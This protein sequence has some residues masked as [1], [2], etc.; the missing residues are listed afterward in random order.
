MTYQDANPSATRIGT[1]SVSCR[2]FIASGGVLFAQF[3]KDAFTLVD[4]G[5][6][7]DERQPVGYF[8][9]GF[10]D[11][12]IDD[13]EIVQYLLAFQSAEIG[14]DLL[15]ATVSLKAVFADSNSPASCRMGTAPTAACP[16]PDRL[17]NVCASS[18]PNQTPP[19]VCGSAVMSILDSPKIYG[20]IP[21]GTTLTP[22]FTIQASM[23]NA[24]QSVDM[25]VG[26]TATTAG[27]SV[28]TQFAKRET[29]N[30]DE[31]SLYYSTD[32]PTGGT[33]SVGGYDINNNEVLETVTYDPRNFFTDYFYETRTYSDLTSTNPTLVALGAP[34]NFDTLDGGFR[35]GLNNTSRP[36]QTSLMAQWSEDINFN[37]RLDGACTIDNAV[38]CT[39]GI[40]KSQGCQRCSLNHATEC[41]VNADCQPPLDPLGNEGTCTYNAGT[42]NFGLGED[43]NINGNNA[44]DKSW[45]TLGGCGWQTKFPGAAGGGVWHT[46]LIRDQAQTDCVA[47][48]A[49]PGKCQQYWIQDD[50]DTIGDNNWWDLLLTP[51]LHKVNQ[52][53]TNGHCSVTT[54]TVCTLSSGCPVGETCIG[55]P[56]YQASIT[57]WA[58]NMLVDIPDTNTQVTMEFDTDI[59]KT[60]GSELFNDATI[61]VQFRGRQ[62]PVSGGNA[63]IT[64]GFNMFHRIN[65]CVDTDGNGSV[66][67][68]GTSQGKLCSADGA[69]TPSNFF[70]DGNDTRLVRGL[71]TTPTTLPALKCTGN[72]GFATACATNADC[73]RHCS[74]KP[75][76]ACI[77]NTQ[78]TLVVNGCSG[79][80]CGACID[81]HPALAGDRCV[82]PFIECSSNADCASVGGTCAVATG[83]DLAR[84]REGSNN[85][86]FYG[87]GGG[88]AAGNHA[89]SSEPYGLPTPLDDDT[90]NGYCSRNDSFNGLDKSVSCESS[91]DC[92]SAG[93]PYASVK[94]C[95]LWKSCSKAPTKGCLNNAGCVLPTE[96]ICDAA[97]PL[98][99]FKDSPDCGAALSNGANPVGGVCTGTTYT[100]V[101]NLPNATADEYVQ[102]NGPGRN[103]GVQVSNGPDL[104]FSTLEDIYGDTG[105]DFQ[106]ALG[107]N[108]REPDPLTKGVP[109]GYGLA[110][111]DMV[112]SWKETRL[113]L[114][115]HTCSNAIGECATLDTA[116]TLAYEG[117]AII[118]LTV[119]DK[120]PYEPLVAARNKND[121]NGDG[122]YT[123]IGKCSSR[124]KGC[125][126]NSEC[127]N[128]SLLP[129][130]SCATNTDCQGQCFNTTTKVFTA[131]ICTTDVQC[132][133]GEV[134]SGSV[135]TCITTDICNADPAFVD[136]QDCNNNGA[137][138]VT[139]GMTSDAET[140]PEIAILDETSAGSHVYKTNF[141]YSTL[142][143]SPGSLFVLQSGTALPVVTARYADR[144]DGSGFSCKNNVDPVVAGIVTSQTTV[145]ATSGLITLNSYAVGNVSTC[146]G[147]TSILCNKNSDCSG[148]GFCN[149]CSNNN[150]IGCAVDADCGA[151]NKCISATGHGDP[152]G[153]AD[154]NEM[155]DLSI[156]LANKSGLDVD[157]VTATLGTSSPNIECIT[158]ASILV[159]SLKNKELS[160]PANY[161]PFQF[162][163]K[164]TV[165]RTDALKEI[166]QAK[167][168]LTIRSSKFDALTRATEFTID[169]DLNASGGGASQPFFEGFETDLTQWGKFTREF[170]DAN[171]RT[172]VLSKG[173][174][175]QY[176]NPFGVNSQSAS[177][178]DCFLGFTSDPTSGKNDWHIHASSTTGSLGRAFEGVQSLHMGIHDVSGPALDTTR[179]KHIMSIKT[180]T[181]INI[182]LAGASPQLNFAQQVSFVDSS[183]GVNVSP[184]EGV[185]RG[186]VEVQKNLAGVPQ[187]SWIKIYP[188]ENGYDQQGTD[189]FSNCEFDPID[190][191][192]TETDFFD[193]ADPNR[194]LGPSSTCFPEFC[195]VHQGQTDYRKSFDQ[196]DIGNASD[197]PGLQGCSGGGCLPANTPTV[198]SNPGT[199]VRPRF[200]LV[201][202]AATQLNL[203]FLFTSIEVA[204]T[205]TMF[206]FFG[207]GDLSGDDGWYIDDIHIDQALDTA[208]TLSV[209]TTTIAS[210]IPCGNCL[211]IT[212]NLDTDPSGLAGVSSPGQI[213]TVTAKT[214]TADKCINGILQYQFWNDV[215]VDGVVGV[216]P[217][218]LL[219]DWTDNANFVAAPLVSTQYGVKVRCSTELSCTGAVASNTA[220]KFAVNC[221]TASPNNW[222]RDGQGEQV[223]GNAVV[224]GWVP[225]GLRV[226]IVRGDLF[227]MRVN[228][229]T[230]VDT[231]GCLANNATAPNGITDVA[232]IPP[233][234]GVY[235][236]VLAH[237]GQ[238]CNVPNVAT[239]REPPPGPPNSQDFPGTGPG[240]GTRDVDVNADPDGS[241]CPP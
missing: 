10:P 38:P 135:G 119:V 186:V 136:D 148:N 176:N 150:A 172:R 37:G 230:N 124:A 123:D 209:D 205:E 210:P 218:T 238:G 30:V 157:D 13:G 120:V 203:R 214:S 29:L 39:Q 126:G 231:G 192:N 96:G 110:V 160:N 35:N 14:T 197:G 62:G 2:P 130:R 131:T 18:H 36:Q 103:Y 25:I 177:N 107:F 45:N 114:D 224:T 82:R 101:C 207:R 85:C 220:V 95:S 137:N 134:C 1:A 182:P 122:D 70:C 202:F 147:N 233:G 106:A 32:F 212:A 219:R 102:K 213:I 68:C 144:D 59:N 86:Y 80:A 12:Y 161:L 73:N 47:A 115:T 196:T 66:D 129:S 165:N 155:I 183:A 146:S 223:G 60:A 54:A 117:N 15:N 168:T 7:R 185:D 184:G 104:R 51:V 27:K 133:G 3:G 232:A 138:D 6:E 216:G 74:L 237:S 23:P 225:P 84:N 49:L 99:C 53:V 108:N 46:G 50:G 193:P 58:W 44:F 83:A 175:C 93:A 28:E 217:D 128:C 139:V 57:D 111:D 162:K 75:E 153:F 52:Q 21:A 149:W 211:L 159:G 164:N 145:A 151:G 152:D 78:C 33:E 198:I 88:V 140:V 173:F 76:V 178:T 98:P 234:A 43:R 63:P 163:V 226:K 64:N 187:G 109:A 221:L 229:L 56:V 169:L 143:N 94:T 5:C 179:L 9:F 156:V 241:V 61:L 195:F 166:L 206:G 154:A 141:P 48:G 158:R 240:I 239:F 24:I 199:W 90:P 65:A 55:D 191:G 127:F 170:L 174:R 180:M 41:S 235:Y 188:F 118:S 4:G 72:T 77:T 105:N 112:V 42:C 222:C 171:K 236:L 121:C 19:V 204:T 208:L 26:V 100:A 116:S 132:A 40:P 97:K 8:T 20:R 71:C 16:D 200:D 189:D 69:S 67:H 34:W 89:H 215:N 113:D 31:V 167:F 190:D 79:G 142:Y 125:T 194:R 22:A 11:R 92:E 17:T 227:T 81:N 87:I 181:P 228:G 201:N 91:T